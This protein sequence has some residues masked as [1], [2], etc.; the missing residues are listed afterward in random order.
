MGSVDM[1]L[2]MVLVANG[3]L[4]GSKENTHHRLTKYCI[5]ITCVTS[6]LFVMVPLRHGSGCITRCIGFMLKRGKTKE[7]IGRRYVIL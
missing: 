3:R 4:K 2:L 1:E 5:I 6:R 7:K